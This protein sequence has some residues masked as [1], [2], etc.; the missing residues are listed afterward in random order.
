M[1]RLS[2]GRRARRANGD[3]RGYIM[4]HCP[5]VLS[6]VGRLNTSTLCSSVPPTATNLPSRKATPCDSRGSDMGAT[7]FH[8]PFDIE[9]RLLPIKVSSIS[10]VGVGPPEQIFP[11]TA[12]RRPSGSQIIPKF[13]LA[14][15]ISGSF[16][17]LEKQK[18]N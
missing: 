16:C 5:R 17:Q 9:D 11:P 15:C 7:N 1:R 10:T 12:N 8:P 3:G 13:A 18:Y 6:F 2:T 4:L 14:C